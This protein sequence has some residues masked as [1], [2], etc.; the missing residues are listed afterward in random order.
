MREWRKSI[1]VASEREGKKKKSNK[2]P[3]QN[4]QQ[5]KTKKKPTHFKKT[6][7]KKEDNRS[8]VKGG[9]KKS[10]RIHLQFVPNLKLFQ[11]F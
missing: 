9:S 4:N 10:N 5:Q 6:F 3:P 2:N 7:L 11:T 8:P 1:R